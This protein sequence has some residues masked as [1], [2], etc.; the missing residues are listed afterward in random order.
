[1]TVHLVCGPPAAGS[2]CA[3]FEA[4]DWGDADVWFLRTLAEPSQRA[5]RLHARVLWAALG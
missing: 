1:M 5:D 3:G 2:I 4:H